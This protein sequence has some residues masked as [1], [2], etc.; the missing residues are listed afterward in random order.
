[1]ARHGRSTRFEKELSVHAPN[2][3]ITAA[4]VAA[5]VRLLAY[6]INDPDRWKRFV[7]LIFLTLAVAAGWWLLAD[8]GFD[9]LLHDFGGQPAGRG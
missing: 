6:A 3:V 9:V 5:V 8:G 2:P 1:V 4:T 7:F